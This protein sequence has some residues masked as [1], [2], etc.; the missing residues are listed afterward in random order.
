M[1]RALARKRPSFA[2]AED[3]GRLRRVRT[4]LGEL[5]YAL[6]GPTEADAQRQ[7]V[8]RRALVALAVMA[9]LPV[10]QLRLPGWQAV[11]LAC[12]TALS[13][14][15]F[16]AYLVFVKKRYFLP[17]VLGTVLDD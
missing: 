13:Y 9:V 3:Q 17:R 11:V 5:G 8:F 12:A 2:L 16:L 4:R 10:Q 1:F 15:V 6:L 7:D 14:D